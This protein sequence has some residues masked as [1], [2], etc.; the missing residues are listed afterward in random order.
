MLSQCNHY[1]LKPDLFANMPGLN[2]TARLLDPI[3]PDVSPVPPREPDFTCPTV[4]EAMHYH[5]LLY[6]KWTDT[7]VQALQGMILLTT[8]ATDDRI[9]MYYNSSLRDEMMSHMHNFYH[10][11]CDSV[12]SQRIAYNTTLERYFTTASVFCSK[13][14]IISDHAFVARIYHRYEDDD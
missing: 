6:D 10:E 14:H 11:D 13:H 12:V 5:D 9:V 7:F 2:A 4:K 1:Q 8:K 3:F